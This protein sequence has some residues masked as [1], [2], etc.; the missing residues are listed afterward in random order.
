MYCA[1]K[2]GD[3]TQRE[4]A[5][6]FNLGHTGSVSSAVRNIG[7]CIENGSLK[8]EYVAIRRTLHVV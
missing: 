5:R 2:D 6:Y 3:F 4:I 1:Q 7:L 8:R